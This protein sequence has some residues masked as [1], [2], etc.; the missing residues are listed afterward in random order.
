MSSRTQDTTD[1]S[2]A[3]PTKAAAGPSG[4]ALT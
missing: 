4:L 1:A 3:A 2:A